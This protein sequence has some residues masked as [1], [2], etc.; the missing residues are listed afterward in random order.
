MMPPTRWTPTTSRESSKPRRYLSPT[1]SAQT[2]PAT[3]PS[4]IADHGTR[5]AQAGVIATRPET[6]PDAAPSVVGWPSR[7]RSTRSQPITAAAVATWV[8]VKARAARPLA[9][10]AEPALKPNQPNHSRP[11]PSM[12]NGR[13]CGL[14]CAFGQPL[15]LPSTIA[16]ASPAAPALMWTAVP[17]AK[18]S[19]PRAASQ[20]APL[21]FA[22]PKLKTQWATGKYT[23]VTHAATKTD[24]PRNLARS[25][26]APEISAGVM[27]ANIS[28]NIEKAVAG[29][30]SSAPFAARDLMASPMPR[31]PNPPKKP[32]PLPPNAIEYP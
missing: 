10:S 30:V 1:A 9:A 27:I 6:A 11:A 7:I 24:Q 25:A 20:P 22:S 8:L 5:K 16:S 32:L 12:T 18:S 14:N 26:M 21:P 28:W 19:T 13:L 15:R 17:P 3:R 23:S 29:I 4:R 2:V 31:E